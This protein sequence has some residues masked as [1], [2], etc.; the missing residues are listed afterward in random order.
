[1]LD[2]IRRSQ[3]VT[4]ARRA[5]R[6]KTMRAVDEVISRYYQQQ[7]DQLD[8][9]RNEIADLRERLR[10]EVGLAADR[11][12]DHTTQTDIRA[13]RD[14]VAVGNAEAARESAEFVRDHM[15]AVSHF[16][17]PHATLE[18][19]LSLAPEG[20]L[21]LEFGVYSGT[22]LG[23]ISKHRDGRQVYG[24]D[25]FEGLPEDWR[26]AFPAGRFAV[27]APPE[28]PG[29]ELVVGWF[30]DT[31]PGFLDSHDGSVDFLHVDADLYSAAVTVLDHVGPRL[32]P[33]SIIVFDEF[34]NYPGWQRHEFKA[35]EEYVA[36]TGL[37]FEYVAYTY[38]NEQVVVKVLGA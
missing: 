32:R 10:L 29:A 23:I 18:Y 25:S 4:Y 11:I 2:R 3:P 22:T 12:I 13:H 24:F 5:L 31:L 38:D 36:R 35:W 1:V 9:L 20:G 26:A 34:F 17:H 30:A 21:A 33:G 6:D 7:S 16:G 19:A 28:V 8:G 37:L 14:I 15:G 27:D